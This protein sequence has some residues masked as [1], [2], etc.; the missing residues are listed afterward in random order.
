MKLK[1]DIFDSLLSLMDKGDRLVCEL[2]VNRYTDTDIEVKV[3]SNG[4]IIETFCTVP[5]VGVLANINAVFVDRKDIPGW[6]Y[7]AVK[8]EL[9]HPN[10]RVR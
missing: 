7:R 8:N 3:Y 10:I 6:L 2:N 4:L 1:K 5:F 9:V